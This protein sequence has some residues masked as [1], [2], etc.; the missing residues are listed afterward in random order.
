MR[1]R[2]G[3]SYFQLGKSGRPHWEELNWLTCC[4]EAALGKSGGR[5]IW[6]SKC[7]GVNGKPALCVEETDR[8]QKGCRVGD[9]GENN[10]R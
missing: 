3:E 7:E 4:G 5:A 10:R 9:K 8:S 6:D 1:G 2:E